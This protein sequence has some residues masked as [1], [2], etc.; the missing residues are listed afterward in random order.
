MRA[1]TFARLVALETLVDAEVGY[2]LEFHPASLDRFRETLVARVS[3][4]VDEVDALDA[5]AAAR[6]YDALVDFLAEL[7]EDDDGIVEAT[8]HFKR[9][10][11]R[12]VERG[13]GAP[14]PEDPAAWAVVL[15]ALLEELLA[16]YRR[17]VP[18]PGTFEPRGYLRVRHLLARGREAAERMTPAVAPE[19]RRELRD[20]MDRLAFA[21]LSRRPPADVLEPLVRDAQRLARRHR[22]SDVTRIGSYVMKQILRRVREPRQP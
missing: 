16:E 2:W 1:D 9:A 10:V 20:A 12:L 4:L 22:P 6:V 21:V 13:M 3:D 8:L 18:E 11:D 15:D 5:V 7:P 17:A 14:G 19:R